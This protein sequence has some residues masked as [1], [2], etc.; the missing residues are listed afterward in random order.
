MD[1]DP[2]TFQHLSRLLSEAVLD[3][4]AAKR[5]HSQLIHLGPQLLELHTPAVQEP[6][7]QPGDSYLH[8]EQS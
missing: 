4:T 1:F 5:L 2:D 6:A 3:G 8:Q 7:L